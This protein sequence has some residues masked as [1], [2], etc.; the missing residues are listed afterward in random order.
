MD[1]DHDVEDGSGILA[2]LED[3]EDDSDAALAAMVRRYRGRHRW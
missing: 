1:S 3:G 2:E